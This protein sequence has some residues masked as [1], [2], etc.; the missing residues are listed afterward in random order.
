MFSTQQP[1]L[2]SATK[3]RIDKA[4]DVLVGK[5]PD[6]KSQVE[7][8]TLA[9]IYKFMHDMDQQA[10]R[11]G[12][13]ATFFVGKY[14]KYAW[15]S[16]YSTKIGGHELIGL[17]GD[18]L[19]QMSLNPNLPPLFR[20]IFKNA[21]LPY[22]DP[23]TLRLFLS[24]I[25]EFSYD[26]SEMLGDA[27]EYLLSV[28][29]SQGDAGQFRTPRHIIDFIVEVVGP[30]KTDRILD[31][32]C[33]TAGFLIAA[34]KYILKTNT[35][36]REGDLLTTKDRKELG[37]NLVGYDISPDMV[38]MSLVNMYLHGF[39][40][41][42]IHEYD[43][44][45]SEERWDDK[46][47]VILANPPFMSPK[48]GIR[49]HG[50]F[51]ISAKR[52]EVLFVDY[53]LE[54]LTPQGKAGIIVPEGII[55]Q[56]GSAYRL[57]REALIK[58]ALIGV[59]SLPSGVFQP[60]SGVKTSVL[61]LDKN[62]ARS[63]PK[64]MFS[65]VKAIGVSLGIKQAIV[66]RNDLP[67]VLL[68]FKAYYEDKPVS[69]H[70]WLVDRSTILANGSILSSEPYR[71]ALAKGGTLLVTLEEVCTLAKGHYSSTQTEPGQYPLIVTAKSPL[72]ASTF[73]IDGDAV[74]VPLISSTGHGRATLSRIHY[75]SGK[76]AVA[77]L[78][79]VLQPKNEEVLIPKYLYYV[80]DGKKDRMAGL[81]KGAANVNMKLEDLAEFQIPLP[82][83]PVQ[84]ALVA[85]LERFRKMIEGARAILANYK[86]EIEIDPKWEMR[87]LGEVCD[88]VSAQI[89]PNT[90]KGNVN[91]VGLENIESDTGE[92]IGE[93][94]V[95]ANT[96]KSNKS[97]FKINDVLYGKLRPNLNK[98]WI[99]RFDGICSTD[100]LVL[101][102]KKVVDPTF[103]AI[104]LRLPEM[105]HEILKGI[106]G[107]QLPRTN[108][109]F[110]SS[111]KIP[112]P[113]LAEQQTIVARLERERA[114][115]E[116]LK[117]LISRL[118]GK[119]KGRVAGLWGE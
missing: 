30:T 5:V 117:G 25:N 49:P 52:S 55:F 45:T 77:N 95:P 13:K 82:P 39:S 112:I 48:G 74:C 61:I 84:E 8:I 21:F 104:Q 14:K 58:E 65:E 111:L 105:N 20:D 100:I 2:D 54:H 80:L 57:L 7:Q 34:F 110:M 60:Y 51:R 23:E 102:P 37:N 19:A 97:A 59:I 103:L 56:D 96:I 87:E 46:A 75:A 22:R 118:E 12:G 68:D 64:I 115:M 29:G 91:Y 62:K 101:R 41:P 38:R 44:L 16:V 78:L 89:I 42:S 1:M 70:S 67:H 3:Q 71:P 66:E 93:Y 6:P 81:M 36:T 108:F 18:A 35:K 33:G 47:D 11:L 73:E 4:R 92:L 109:T 107:S 72:T 31:P 43:T 17:Y 119:I 79:A 24:V 86:P 116:M 76:F 69:L 99:A 106:S 15:T 114:E 85:E 63:N 98:V 27:Y 40:N 88:N 94:D 32:A 26:H 83:L 28:L 90:I 113:P 9:L 10:E 50:N 53:M